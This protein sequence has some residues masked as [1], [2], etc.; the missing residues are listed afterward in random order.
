[1]RTTGSASVEGAADGAS[2]VTASASAGVVRS[3]R[4]V[5][6]ET[7]L[8]ITC[9]LLQ[10]WYVPIDAL[11]GTWVGWAPGLAI[12]V[13]ACAAIGCANRRQT[14]VVTI[15]ISA[16]YFL[17]S[18]PGINHGTT[19]STVMGNTANYPVFAIVARML[20]SFVRRFGA[21]A[22]DAREE[23]IQATRQIELERHRRLLHDP[24]SLLRY[25][26]DPDLDPA[27]AQAARAQALAEANRISAYLTG[28]SSTAAP[29]RGH[30][31]TASGHGEVPLETAVRRAAAGFT[32]LP[33][34]LI[35]DLADGISLELA[36]A[37]ALSAATATVLHNVRR[38]AGPVTNVVVH[39]DYDPAENEWELTIRDDGQGF[40]LASSTPGYG[41]TH[42]TGTALAEH[43]IASHVHSQ[44]GVG[45]TITIR[46]RPTP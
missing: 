23:A 11:V 42:I 9:L 29:P 30:L 1:M 17:V 39:A 46:G 2:S 44:P 45:T 15:L 43:Q 13:T 21:A 38:H 19:L 36:P 12:N 28:S 37:R 33:L 18:Y 16:V 4:W 40:D 7:V 3:L 25:L 8:A 10:P 41:L 22:D 5:C 27:I 32:D 34:E 14:A 26:A 24:A 20:V 6:I 35:L 31:S